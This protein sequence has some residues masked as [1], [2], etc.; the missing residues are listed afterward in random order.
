M[1]KIGEREIDI[2]PNFKICPT[3]GG[4]TNLAGLSLTAHYAE[5]P[6]GMD[7]ADPPGYPIGCSPTKRMCCDSVCQIGIERCPKLEDEKP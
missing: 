2:W 6:Y 5:P 4:K 1:T 7:Q 3:C